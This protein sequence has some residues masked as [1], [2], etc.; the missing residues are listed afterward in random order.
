MAWTADGRPVTLKVTAKLA[1]EFSEMGAAHVDRPLS[2]RRL[3]VYRKVLNDGAFRPVTWARAHCTETDQM[4]RVNGKHTSILFAGSD[5]SKCQDLYAVV[6]D[7]ICDT[8]EDVAKLYATFDS[9]TA[10]R[11]ATDINKSFASV[12]PELMGMDSKFLNLMVSALHFRSTDVS[13]NHRT[14]AAERAEALLDNIEFCVWAHEVLLKMNM[15]AR[16]LQRMPVVAAMYGSYNKAKAAA[17]TFWTAVRDETGPSPD[18]PDRRLAKFLTTTISASV[19]ARSNAPPRFKIQPREYFVKSV[20]AWNAWR[21][22]E[23]TNLK[24][25]IDA[26]IPAFV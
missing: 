9:S 24:Y 21:K 20:T 13:G 5:L 10:S 7:Y 4:L 6:E 3:G 15:T 25:F 17:L 12:V 18:L 14:P 16:H 23:G 2:E 19:G 11:T 22:N 26:K 8:L 1:K